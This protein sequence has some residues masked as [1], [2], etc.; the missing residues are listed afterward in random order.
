[1]PLYTVEG[2]VLRTREYGERD[3][4]V[5]LVDREGT[6]R[7]VLA[8]GVR[9]P[10]SSLAAGVQPYT[11][12]RFLLWK[13]RSLDGVSQVQVL[14]ALTGL[15][16]SL[17]ALAAAA[18]VAE[19]AEAFTQEGAP[20]PGVFPVVLQGLRG[21]AAA[22]GDGVAH[23]LWLRHAELRLLDLAGLGPQLDACQDC[24]RPLA[25]PGGGPAAG[26]TVPG[27]AGARSAT[28]PGGASGTGA[29]R[30]EA[31]TG[32]EA[33]RPAGY[34]AELG[35]ALCQ[36][37]LPGRPAALPLDAATWQVLRQARRLTPE[38]AVRL[39]PGAAVLARAADVVQTHLVYH[40]GR[41]FRSPGFLA[42][43]DEARSP[44]AP[45]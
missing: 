33:G 42:I 5:T 44:G 6:R 15:R 8:K 3:R 16:G 37:C 2:I 7:T 24:G 9:R 36:G 18:Y 35:G 27:S 4:L 26:R 10:R 1:M 11:Y 40:L 32:M 34:S 22:P 17:E 39:R 14:D 38:L 21:L 30:E 12:S 23:A 41:S 31:G 45:G 13:G 19:L 25:P 43:L 20:S 28:L 29:R